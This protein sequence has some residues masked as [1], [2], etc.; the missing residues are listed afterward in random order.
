MEGIF[1]KADER[2]RKL[3]K[4]VLEASSAGDWFL[5]GT[6]YYE[7]AIQLEKE[8]KDNTRERRLGYEMKLR[9]SQDDLKRYKTSG[10]VRKVEILATDNSC[11]HCLKLN[12][13][14]F[15]L[16]EALKNPPIPVEEC[17]QEMGYGCR[18]TYLPVV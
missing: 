13:K 2:W 17:D 9:H 14:T 15:S 1:S 8:E 6:T 12:G 3:N 16:A 18:C 10:V 5:A 4:K 11:E 7:M